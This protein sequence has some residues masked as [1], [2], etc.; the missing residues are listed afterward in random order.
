MDILF[1]L[2]AA[3]ILAGAVGAMALRN[4][5]HCALSAAVAFAGLAAAFLR[6]QAEFAGFAQLLVYV[7]AVAVL[8]AMVLLV[9]RNHEAH[10]GSLAFKP[11]TLGIGIAALAAGTLVS[12]I[13]GSSRAWR[14]PGA[15]PEA[16]VSA[17]KAIGDVMMTRYVVALEVLGLLLTAALIGAVIIALE[18]QAAARRPDA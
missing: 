8:V 5:V 7:G 12:A 16:S 10:P 17:V 2:N 6:L 15:A 13:L 9:T 14:A 1:L 18:H 4:V 11:W 3:V